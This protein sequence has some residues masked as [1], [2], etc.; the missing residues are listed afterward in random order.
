MENQ[1]LSQNLTKELFFLTKSNLDL[2]REMKIDEEFLSLGQDAMGVSR[3]I[4][5]RL[6]KVH[7]EIK[8]NYRELD[9]SGT[10]KVIEDMWEEIMELDRLISEDHFKIR[11]IY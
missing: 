11:T 2:S 4:H 3:E 5:D 9:I 1:S 6:G 7:E 10:V 8:E